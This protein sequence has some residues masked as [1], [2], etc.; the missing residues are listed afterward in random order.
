MVKD[1]SLPAK[2]KKLRLLHGYSQAYVASKLNISRQAY[3]HY[4][5]GRRVPNNEYLGLLAELYNLQIY[6]LLIPDIHL[7]F[8]DLV[9]EEP[10][11]PKSYAE[12]EQ[13][14]LKAFRRLNDKDKQKLVKH[15]E[16][17]TWKKK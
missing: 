6:D 11:Y 7:D 9:S 2:L 5:S 14:L 8:P 15:A 16:A 3:Q 12:M 13:R 4:E 17:M 1:L 10:L